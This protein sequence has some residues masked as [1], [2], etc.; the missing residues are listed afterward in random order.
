MFYESRNYWGKIDQRLNW[1][2]DDGKWNDK[3]WL[4]ATRGRLAMLF[5]QTAMSE[6]SLERTSKK[7]TPS[8]DGISIGMRIDMKSCKNPCI[9]EFV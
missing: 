6:V 3:A 2:S 7:I 4:S 1:K 5:S 8:P 9:G